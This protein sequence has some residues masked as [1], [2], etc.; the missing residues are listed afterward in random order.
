MA[1]T[2]P[3]DEELATRAGQGD[4]AACG[5][6]VGR[7]AVRV[8]RFLVRSCGMTADTAEDLAQD[9]WLKVWQNLHR[10]KPGHFRGWLLTVARNAAEDCRKKQIR[11]K[12]QPL[13]AAHP[14]ATEGGKVGRSAE[15]QEDVSRLRMC[16]DR[17]ATEFRAVFEGFVSGKTYEELAT[18]GTVPVNTVK[19][20]LSRTRRELRICMGVEER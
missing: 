4:R 15:V 16:L 2:A 14:Q 13:T 17:L 20:R 9:V 8:V 11:G 19:S 5:E 1:T 18:E 6:L 10:W 7:Y 3:T 12:T